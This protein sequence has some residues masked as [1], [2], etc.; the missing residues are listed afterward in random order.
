MFIP[1]LLVL[2]VW[3]L[4]LAATGGPHKALWVG[5]M[6]VLMLAPTWM[7]KTFGSLEMDMRS[8]VA[9]AVLAGFLF[10]Q[11]ENLKIRWLWLDALLL[12]LVATQVASGF[13]A[14]EIRPLT[15][16]EIMRRWLP[17]YVMGRLFFQS[18]DDLDRVLPIASKLVLILS[19]YAI[20]EALLKFNLI[21][22]ILGKQFAVLEAGEGYRWGIK[23][24]Q[25][26]L[27]HPIFFGMMLVM[28]FPWAVEAG[29][30]ARRK[31]GPRWWLSL[32]LLALGATFCTASR[33]AIIAAVFTVYVTLFFR[34][35]KL[36]IVMILL[37]ILGG[38]GAYYGK[39]AM[40]QTLSE[41]A[42]ESKEAA[43]TIVIDGEEVEYTGTKHRLLLYRAYGK[44][45]RQA[46]PFGYGIRMQGVPI[47]K[48]LA[49]RFSSID[50]HYLLFLLQY[51]YMGIGL[52]VAATLCALAYLAVAAWDP[53]RPQSGFAGALFGSLLAVALLLQTV[54]FASD[55]AVVWLFCAGL[56]GSLHSLPRTAAPAR[57]EEPEPS[58]VPVAENP[59]MQRRLTP[60]WAPTRET[61]EERP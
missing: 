17:A 27:N 47:E 10:F 26:P 24:A 14:G 52:F 39:Q 58:D 45:I 19:L 48:H 20:G 40:M 2:V 59:V 44:A 33:G 35:P 51:G 8:G 9:V 32:P 5:W 56:A 50:N 16:P 31:I 61:H 12:L 54:W 18:A 1:L 53:K 36:R 4:Y 57:G 38:A 41:M 11:K 3:T 37:L 15:I 29:R 13:G 55:F 60:G 46:G 34:R 22:E 42:G 7:V 25:G 30:R 23:R 28:L 43:R 21:N 49:Y 6:S